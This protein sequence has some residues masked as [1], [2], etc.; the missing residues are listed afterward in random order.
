MY[1]TFEATAKTGP[2]NNNY[3]KSKYNLRC[4]IC[5]GIIHVKYHVRAVSGNHRWCM[6][7]DIT[8]LPS[9]KKEKEKKMTLLI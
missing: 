9:N 6:K 7:N 1:Q 8:E 2:W 5:K 3:V 4:D